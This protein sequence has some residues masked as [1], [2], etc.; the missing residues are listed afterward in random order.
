M[1]CVFASFSNAFSESAV[2]TLNKNEDVNN[3]TSKTVK[4]EKLFYQIY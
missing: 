2:L 4:I 1:I 3:M